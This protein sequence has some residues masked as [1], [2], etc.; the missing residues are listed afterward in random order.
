MSLGGI[1]A[2]A[3]GGGASQAVDVAN[4]QIDK[5]NQMDL[6]GYEQQLALERMEAQER[7][8]QAG[9]LAEVKGPIADARAEYDGR[10]TQQ[11]VRIETDGM[12][13]RET[14]L[15]PVKVAGAVAVKKAENEVEADDDRNYATDPTRRAGARAKASDK[16][17][18]ASRAAAAATGYK[19][20]REQAVDKL[21]DKAATLRAA[22]DEEGAKR[23]LQQAADM[24]GAGGT[25]SYGDVVQAAKMFADMATAEEKA[26]KDDFEATPEEKKARQVRIREYRDL[27]SSLGGGVAEKKNVGTN[28]PPSGKASGKGAPYP[29]GTRLSGP[30]GKTYIVKNGVPVLE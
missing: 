12:V 14:R 8:R 10:V 22:G 29:D 28:A 21:R 5:Q 24:T 25:K 11:R 2:S 18:S 23:V 16:E 1:I 4:K 7:L 17:G 9:V 3:I 20:S 19:L 6:R 15:Q 13:D 30:G 26:L 27:A